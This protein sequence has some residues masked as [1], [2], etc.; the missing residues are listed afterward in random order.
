MS[1]GGTPLRRSSKVAPPS[2][3][4]PF[5]TGARP[6][7]V[8]SRQHLHLAA[9]VAE[10][11]SPNRRSVSPP[12]ESAAAPT[13]RIRQSSPTDEELIRLPLRL[14][15][16]ACAPTDAPENPPTASTS[17]FRRPSDSPPPGQRASA[18]AAPPFPDYG[19]MSENIAPHQATHQA[20]YLAIIL[21]VFLYFCRCSS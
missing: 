20:R 11:L 19:D 18:G 8:Q 9:V 14:S 15:T 16:G 4:T 5:S 7:S 21:C 10:P 17:D 12:S 3:E 1:G 6:H 2:L 13:T